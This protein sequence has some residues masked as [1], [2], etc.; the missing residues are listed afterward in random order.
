MKQRSAESVI[1]YSV[2]DGVEDDRGFGQQ[3][4]NFSLTVC[5]RATLGKN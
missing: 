3:F 5:K 4:R 2:N 1:H